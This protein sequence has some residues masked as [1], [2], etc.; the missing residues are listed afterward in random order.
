[1]TTLFADTSAIAKR[2]VVE[3]GSA[4]VNSWAQPAAGNIVVISALAV[5]ELFSLLARKQREGSIAAGDFI[6]IRNDILLDVEKQYLVASLDEATLNRARNLVVSY[7]LRTLDAIQLACA[8]ETTTTLGELMTFVSGD[9]NLL[10][11]AAAEGFA[12]DNPYAHP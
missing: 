4:W 2:F 10:A 8:I 12:T 3:V 7:P 9:N 1:L 6:N 5:V 11:A